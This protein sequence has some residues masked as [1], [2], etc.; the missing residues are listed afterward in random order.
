MTDHTAATGSCRFPHAAA[1]AVG[2]G[3]CP[4]GPADRKSVV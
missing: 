1:E 3:G 2:A 4:A